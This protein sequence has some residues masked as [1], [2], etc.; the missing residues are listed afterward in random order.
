MY[1]IGSKI[2]KE[3]KGM[4][5]T[6]FKIII[7]GGEAG[8]GRGSGKCILCKCIQYVMYIFC[9]WVKQDP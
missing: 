6:K 9:I 1:D 2:M 4:M 8:K 7:C 5:S 3:S